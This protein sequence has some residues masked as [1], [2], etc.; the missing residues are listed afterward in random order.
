MDGGWTR[1]GAGSQFAV[2]VEEFGGC[3]ERQRS[4]TW[5]TKELRRSPLLLGDFSALA[6]RTR[7]SNGLSLEARSEIRYAGSCIKALVSAGHSV[8]SQAEVGSIGSMDKHYKNK[9]VAMGALML[10]V[11]RSR[12]CGQ[13]PECPRSYHLD[14]CFPIPTIS[15]PVDRG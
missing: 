3:S 8:I 14:P 13:P 2:G 10:V 11:D 15:N 4:V 9:A 5:W 6:V 12:T 7:K 1:L